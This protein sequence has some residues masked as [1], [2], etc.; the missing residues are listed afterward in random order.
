MKKKVNFKSK[1]VIG[2]LLSV[3]FMG[4]GLSPV[5]APVVTELAC[6]V[7]ECEA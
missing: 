2:A 4:F 6:Q 5:G 1:R 7:V 3:L